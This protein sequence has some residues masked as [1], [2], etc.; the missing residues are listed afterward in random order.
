[1]AGMETQLAVAVLL[2][3]VLAV[4]RER[5]LLAGLL[6]G[7]AVLARPDLGLW[8][9]PVLAWAW[10]RKT[11]DGLRAAGGAAAV[12]LPWVAFTTATYG[13]PI[14][15]TIV[16][17]AVSYSTAPES[18]LDV[19]AW[20]AWATHQMGLSA[21]AML[22]G[23]MPFFED[24]TLVAA[25]IPAWVL[26]LVGIATMVF[27]GVGAWAS[28][29]VAN[30]WP[31]LVFVALFVAFWLV[32]VP[33]VGYFTWYLPPFTAVAA[34]LAG[35]GIERLGRHRTWMRSGAGAALL[36]AFAIHLPWSIPLEARVQAEIEEGIRT[37]VGRYLGAKVAPGEGVVTEPAGYLGYY[38]RATLYDYPGLTSRASLAALRSLPRSERSVAGLAA[39]L[40][41]SWA[42]LRPTEWAE[43]ERTHPDVAACYVPERTFGTARDP[44]VGLNGLWK[45][46]PDWTFVVLRRSGCGE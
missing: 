4:I 34:V 35:A 16:A 38:S 25:P 42:V 13:S 14:P 22:R 2:A 23:F 30:W 28:R 43:L 19:G 26:S 5:A 3:G 24:G 6:G 45:W 44:V 21:L 31:I 37:E 1:M 7:M 17:K 11:S 39:A 32:F 46:N 12:L 41:P 20:V 10:A 8:L 33:P 18:L 9:L 36:V 15:Q 40:R 27:I 29:R